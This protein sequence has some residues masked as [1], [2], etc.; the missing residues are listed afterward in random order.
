M[1][2]VYKQCNNK[3]TNSPGMYETIYHNGSYSLL[4]GKRQ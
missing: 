1:E 3:H 2:Q 4:F